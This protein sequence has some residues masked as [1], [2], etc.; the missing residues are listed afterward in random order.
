MHNFENESVV[1]VQKRAV[2]RVARAS[3]GV[4]CT[5]PL[6][7]VVDGW[8]DGD[9]FDC[10][11]APSCGMC[12]D[13]PKPDQHDTNPEAHRKLVAMLGEDVE[14]VAPAAPDAE[15]Q[16]ECLKALQ[17]DR[18]VARCVGRLRCCARNKR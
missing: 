2:R 6:L 18:F 12:Q 8:M 9:L 10:H 13:L 14:A 5:G 3:C 16:V 17:V 15:A 11:G 7:L 1:L 4:C